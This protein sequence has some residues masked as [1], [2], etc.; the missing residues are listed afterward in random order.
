MRKFV[1][2]FGCVLRNFHPQETVEGEMIEG[3][4]SGEGTSDGVLLGRRVGI[5]AYD[6]IE[7]TSASKNIRGDNRRGGRV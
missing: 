6:V 3:G 7:I 4:G 2:D 5:E 1:R